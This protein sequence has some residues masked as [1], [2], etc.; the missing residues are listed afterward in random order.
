MNCLNSTAGDGKNIEVGS[1]LGIL[2]ELE[3][4]SL[5]A[6]RDLSSLLLFNKNKIH[7]IVPSA[8]DTRHIVMH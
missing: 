1:F 7:H 3:W 6:R 2:G 4:P 8:V 5:E